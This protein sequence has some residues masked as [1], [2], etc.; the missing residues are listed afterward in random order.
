[1]TRIHTHAHAHTHTDELKKATKEHKQQD[2]HAPPQTAA[3]SP[4]E[5]LFKWERAHGVDDANAYKVSLSL[6]VY[7]VYKVSLNACKVSLSLRI[8]CLQGLSLCLQGLSLSLRIWLQGLSQCLQGLSLSLH[9]VDD[10]NAYKVSLYM[11]ICTGPSL[12][13]SWGVGRYFRY[14]LGC[15]D[16]PAVRPGVWEG[17][18]C[19][20]HFRATKIGFFQGFSF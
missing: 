5:A 15:L 6:C 16:V 11:H 9:G 12:R 17:T 3:P 2:D 8:W 19:T 20:S 18:L 4:A 10:A 1:M 13:T 7:G 14:V